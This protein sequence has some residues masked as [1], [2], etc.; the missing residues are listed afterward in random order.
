MLTLLNL[1]AGITYAE[2]TVNAAPVLLDADVAFTSAGAL[3]GGRLVVSGL[4]AEDRV[5]ILAEGNGAG[6]IGLAGSDVLYGGVTIGSFAGGVGGDFTITFNAAADGAAVDALIQRLAYQTI[7][8]TPTA[9]R[10]LVLNVIDGSGD[11]L[12]AIG[13]LLALGSTANPFNGF[14]VGSNSTPA[15]VDLDGDG[16]LDLVAGNSLGSLLAWR[17]TGTSAAPTFTAITGTDNPFE[18][19]GV[20]NRATPAFVDLDADGDL[21]LV[22]GDQIGRL[23]AWR[24]TG[25]TASPA[26]TALTGSD[27]PFAAI[28]VS[29][30]SA[31]AFVDLDGDGD[32]DLVSGERYGGFLAWRNTGSPAAPA[33]TA[34]GGTESPFQFLS[35]VLDS[36]P[37]FLD[38]DGDGDLDLISG[39]AFGTF[40][41]WRNTG[42][43][44]A[45]AFT[46]MDNPFSGLDAGFYTAPAFMDLDGDG[47]LDFVAGNSSG[48][49][50]VWRND[51]RPPSITV[52]VTAENDAPV[53]TSAATASFTENATGTVYQATATD[54]E[55][56]TSFTWSLSGADAG[57][58]E[59][60][61]TGALTFRAVPDFETPGD[62]DRDGVYAVTITA[63]DGTA[64]SAPRSVAITVVDVAER[65]ALTGL[66][67]SVIFAENAAPQLLDADVTFSLGDA[68]NG[69]RLVVRGL[70]AE[71]RVSILAEGSGAGQIGLAGSDVLYGGVTIGSFAGGVGGDFTVIFNAAADGAAVDALIQR[72]AYQTISDT[73]TATRRLSIDIVDGAGESLGVAIGTLTALNGTSP[74]PFG[75][76]LA[77]GPSTP[78]FVDLDGDGDLDLVA[79]N[80]LGSLLAWRNTG[81]LAAPVFT[82]I[83]GTDNPFALVG[84]ERYAAP[85]FVDLD[86]DGDLDLVSGTE[87]G[88]ILAWRNTGTTASPAFT[89]LTGSDNPFAAIDVSTHSTPA[90]V[91]LDGDGD[92]DLVSGERDG[93]FLAWR[94]TGSPAAPA[95][96]A[97]GG[98]ENPFDSLSAPGM[99]KPAFV[100]LDNDGDLDLLSGALFSSSLLAWRNTGSLTAPAF[101]ALTGTDNPFGGVTLGFGGAPAFTDLDGDG[102]LDLVVGDAVGTLRVWR[103]AGTPLPTITVTVTAENDAPVITSAATA[104]ITENATGTVYQA[105]ATDPEGTTSFI[106][107]LSGAD[108]GLFDISATGAVTFKASPDFEAPGDAGGDNSYDITVSA[109]DGTLSDSQNVAITVANVIDPV[110]RLGGPGADRLTGTALNDTLS[111][112]DGNDTLDG[113]LGADSME[114]GA[115]SDTYYIDDAGDVMLELAGGGYDRVVTAFN[116]TLAAE[117]ERLSLTGTAD[118]NGTGNALANRLEGNAGRNILDG[119]EGNDGLYGNAGNDTLLGGGGNDTLDGGLGADSM[120]GG[121]GSDTYYIDDAG[122]VMLELAGGGYDRVVTAFNWTLAAE[123]ERLSLSGT[124]NLNGTGNALANRLDG[125]AGANILDGGEGN[126]G[127]YGN[128]GNDTLLGGGGNDTLDGGLGADS[129]EG[130]A[131]NDTYY[132]DDAGD[133]MLELAGGGYDRVVAGFSHTL[134]AEFERLSLTGTADVNG[135]GNALANRLEGNAGA[136]TLDGGDGRDGLFGFGGS[137]TLLGG[138]GHDT[139]DGGLGADSME[140]GAGADLFVF[141]SV[142]E[143][144]GDVIADFTVAQMDRIDV[145]RIDANPG[146]A[147]DQ[148]FVWIGDAGFGNVAGQLRFESGVLEGDVN[149]DNVA[150]F[151]IGLTGVA[152]LTTA[153]IWL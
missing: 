148:P 10:S 47:D 75:R 40:S 39:E 85:A 114:G 97:L 106:W 73:P 109:S 79:G 144:A 110:N 44:T 100:D 13:P 151:Q 133:V 112:G 20:E 33:F 132:L 27:N 82:D 36:K 57:L 55:G 2:N 121:A 118:V 102:D 68:L 77:S 146:L 119:G 61:S 134:A 115:G 52:T 63:N 62:A 139:L 23:L 48:R 136:N 137:D 43:L 91:D 80:F 32:L 87:I 131:G 9:T 60:S 71:D 83:T 58:F 124:A 104:S 7:S 101:T 92:L 129:M 19:V 95:F 65:A 6:Q 45:P 26:F 24:N 59:I 89:A 70:L 35:A 31:P 116:W 37:A 108:A 127:L 34:L 16:D 135:T 1:A 17:N 76:F 28:D 113:G 128:A 145:R 66:G 50:Q 81:S 98:T 99:S 21:D 5:S 140:G 15:F 14:D 49:F 69:G 107:S 78:A 143:T 147:G 42:S 30:R 117:F 150:D 12:L 8:D 105:T 25:T 29:T 138:G 84:V 38:L 64:D 93:Y 74:Y 86:A 149:G 126:D 152:S 120:E 22:S 94:N 51:V 122:D 11:S 4:L 41:A 90:F 67:P 141:N 111:G 46:G 96:T 72:L 125:N 18:L 88:R 54:P 130:G 56:T 123:F 142:G 53:I 103:N 3:A 153:N